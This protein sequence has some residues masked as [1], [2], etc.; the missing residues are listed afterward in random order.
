MNIFTKG[1]AKMNEILDVINEVL[2]FLDNFL[3]Y[4]VIILFIIS[5]QDS[6]RINKLES[7]LNELDEKSSKD[8][9]D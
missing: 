7:K 1:L 2:I 4:L 8:S 9:P 3:V 6:G 5:I